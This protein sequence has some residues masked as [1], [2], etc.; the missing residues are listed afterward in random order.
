[1]SQF[2]R[3]DPVCYS[4]E[5]LRKTGLANAHEAHMQ[6]RVQQLA[7]AAHEQWVAVVQ[8][9]RSYED[10]RTVNVRNLAPLN[11]NQWITQ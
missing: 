2:K 3:G 9:G 8:F 1:M 6:G 10:V 5:F 11:P 7:L 4:I